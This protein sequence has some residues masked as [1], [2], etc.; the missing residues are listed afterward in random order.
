MLP[1]RMAICFPSNCGRAGLCACHRQRSFWPGRH[2]RSRSDHHCSTVLWRADRNQPGRERCC[3]KG[4][5][6]KT[7]EYAWDTSA[8]SGQYDLLALAHDGSEGISDSDSRTFTI[9]PAGTLS[10]RVW[11]DLD[12]DGVQ[13]PDEP[14][15]T[16]V[17]VQATAA[18]SISYA[19]P[20]DATGIYAFALLPA[21]AYTLTVDESTIPSQYEF[22]T[23]A[24]VH[25][26]TV[27]E[28]LA[29]QSTTA[30][31]DADFGY[32]ARSI[33][34]GDTIWYDADGDGVQD[35]GEPGLGN[36]TLDLYLDD[37][38]SVFEPVPA[39]GSD[40]YVGSTVSNAA[41]AYMLDVPVAGTYFV[42]VTD[43]YGLLMGLSH[44]VGSHSISDP[45]PPIP[46]SK[47]RCTRMSILAMYAYLALATLLSV[48]WYGRMGTAMVCGSWQNLRLLA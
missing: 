32:K 24:R 31:S 38:D 11:N 41:G 34:L 45:S 39:L 22:V 37:G 16:G 10:N 47:D 27:V 5:S 15:I 23:T 35:S 46:L 40:S 4:D 9:Q 7:Y 48:I 18:N 3:E 13:D 30:D 6:A 42:D 36:I 21:G 20:T 44:S 1:T 25:T 2:P 29:A 17:M 26:A 28:G 12:G 14:G 19:A 8:C 33:S 43:D